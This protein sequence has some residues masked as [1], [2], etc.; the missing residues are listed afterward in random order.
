MKK[1]Y[2]NFLFP[3]EDANTILYNS[4][5]GAMA[6]L[7]AEHTE[8]FANWSEKE[9]EEKTPE[10]ASTLYKNGYMIA[11]EVSELDMIQYDMLRERFGNYALSLT[12]AITRDCN[13]GCRYC[14]EKDILDKCYM[15]DETK[16]AVVKYV[17]EHVIRGGSLH[18][19]WYGGEPLLDMECI[20]FLTNA[21]LDICKNKGVEYSADIITNGYLLNKDVVTKLMKCKVKYIQ[22][23]LDGDEKTHNK[24][25]PLKSGAPSYQ[26]IWNN[27]LKLV[28][29]QNDIKIALRVNVDKE[30]VDALYDVKRKVLEYNMQDLILVYP[31]KVH[32]VEGCH[33]SDVCYS[34]KEFAL[35]EQK[36]N[37]DFLEDGIEQIPKPRYMVC[38]VDNAHAMVI[39]CNGN[40]YKCYKQIGNESHC[41]GNIVNDKFYHEEELYK[42]LLQDITKDRKCLFCKYLPIC[43]GGCPYEHL[44]NGESCT[45]YKYTLEKYMKYC[46]KK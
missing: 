43:M 2:Y 19:T 38:T 23:T 18:I 17:D 3:G 45:A 44:K 32:V 46:F 37:C 6:R 39:D 22:I 16:K 10:F 42:Y 4:R 15:N 11:D 28:E 24:R 13:F 26:M 20:A 5:T 1:S 7:D 27:I 21:F 36:Y 31:G 9:L 30:N 35:L 29:F 34:N 12:L 25:R 14:Y 40:M 8:Q 41:I 33:N